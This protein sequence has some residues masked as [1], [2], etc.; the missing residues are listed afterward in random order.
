MERAIFTYKLV[1]PARSTEIAVGIGISHEC[2]N[3]E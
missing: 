3:Q 2:T 1:G